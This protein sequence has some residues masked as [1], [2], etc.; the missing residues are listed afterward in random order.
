M[1][2][3]CVEL[4]EDYLMYGGILSQVH[5]CRATIKPMALYVSFN[6]EL[7]F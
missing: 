7:L 1:A 3:A 4:T 5:P 6:V 2:P